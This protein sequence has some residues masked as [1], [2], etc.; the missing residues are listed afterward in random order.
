[1]KLGRL[2]L[3]AVLCVG[4]V[5]A[6][7]YT[8]RPVQSTA[9][10][11]KAYWGLPQ[12][13]PAADVTSLVT[14]PGGYPCDVLANGPTFNDTRADLNKKLTVIWTCQPQNFV[15]AEVAPPTF[16]VHMACVGE[17]PVQPRRIDIIDATWGGP[18]GR[19]VDV[20]QLV[21]DICSDGPT[22]C[23]VP[24]M[25]Y[26]FGMP[27]R[28]TKT[29]RIRYTCNGERTPARMATENSVADLRCERISDLSYPT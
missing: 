6:C 18:D 8:I 4:A 3:L 12:A 15:L 24:A 10:I 29:L 28:G 9:Q 14:C 26:I 27:D 11:K 1:M 21:R 7:S 2:L 13:G 20:T 16:K 17:R 23:Q 5:A 25:A 19:Q 22:R